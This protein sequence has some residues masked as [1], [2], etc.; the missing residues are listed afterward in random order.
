[1]QENTYTTSVLSDLKAEK[2]W[3]RMKM[4]ALFLLLMKT[5]ILVTWLYL[6]RKYHWL[7]KCT[8]FEALL[9]TT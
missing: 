7:Q 4:V 8:I 9:K 6:W 1:M 3:N 5:G 2:R